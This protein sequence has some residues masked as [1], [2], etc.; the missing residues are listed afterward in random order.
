VVKTHYAVR[1]GAFLACLVTIGIHL[2]EHAYGV[3]AWLLLFLQFAIYP[4]LVYLRAKHSAHPV[5]AELDN[6]LLDS[7]LLGV[8]CGML[9][10]PLWITYAMTSATLLNAVVNRAGS[11]AL[12]SLACT[13]AG[14]ILGMSMGEFHYLPYTSPLVTALCFFGSLAYA[15]AVGR[16]LYRLNRRLAR[17]RDEVR[18]SEA[19]YRLIAENAADL[20]ALV[21]LQGRWQY[22]SPSYERLLDPRDLEAGADALRRLHPDDAEMLRAALVRAETAAKPRELALR[23]VDR[24]GRIRQLRTRVHPVGDKVELVS[25]DVTELRDSEEKLLLAAHALEGMTEAIMITAADGTIQTVNRAFC[26]ITGYSREDVLGHSETTV[27]SGLQPPEFYDDLY[28]KVAREGYWSGT[29]WARRKNGSVYREWRS[30]RA[31]R[32]SSGRVTH[33]VM[34]F[35]EVGAS[36][37]AVE[38]S[39][40]A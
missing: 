40:R 20:I 26:G 23:L 32:D 13:A 6:L 12:V 18:E 22:T 24:E 9:G 14:A 1:T 27:R 17:A 3:A 2:W 28:A 25:Q 7:V 35:Y 19:R 36:G 31:V 5:Q 34:V 11:G 29:T 10:F 8:W 37:P 30:V 33:Y 38:N 4:H 16:I 21:D 39:L 15:G